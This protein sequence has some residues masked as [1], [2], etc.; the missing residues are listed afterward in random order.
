MKRWQKIAGC[1][2][3]VFLII[4][5]IGAEMNFAL[6]EKYNLDYLNSDS[7]VTD[8]FVEKIISYFTIYEILLTVDCCI[9]VFLFICLWRKGGR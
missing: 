7:L 3:I 1:I 8:R 6:Y 5:H 2:L 9:I 4:L